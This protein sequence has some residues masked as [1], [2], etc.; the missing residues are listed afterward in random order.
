MGVVNNTK[1]LVEMT[2]SDVPS[3]PSKYK[4][5]SQWKWPKLSNSVASLGEKDN[6]L[7]EEAG[8]AGHL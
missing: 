8:A 5:C 6:G 7:A 1:L 3:Q 2:P 4:R